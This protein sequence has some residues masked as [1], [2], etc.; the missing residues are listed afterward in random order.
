[1]KIRVMAILAFLAAGLMLSS[2]AALAAPLHRSN[3]FATPPEPGDG[4]GISDTD[5][6]QLVMKDGRPDVA[7]RMLYRVTTP[8][9]PQEQYDQHFSIAVDYN[10]IWAGYSADILNTPY[11]SNGASA[12]FPALP[13]CVT[14]GCNSIGMGEWVGVGGADGPNLIQTGVDM[15]H[16]TAWY[17]ML[18]AAAVNVFLINDGDSM[19]ADVALNTQNGKWYINITDMTTG[20]YYANYF[21]YQPDRNTSEWIVETNGGTGS[22]P[23]FRPIRFTN[24]HWFD[25]QGR[26]QTISSSEANPTYKEISKRSQGGCA[27]PTNPGSDDESFTV[28]PTC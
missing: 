7:A 10:P 25:N 28:S 6:K 13:I 26:F 4:L 22:Q 21:S 5:A 20:Q 27:S 3:Q 15:V 11:W 14:S 1:M 18:P 8:L 16:K 2:P 23:N 17:E 12:N 19:Y 9:P 24:A